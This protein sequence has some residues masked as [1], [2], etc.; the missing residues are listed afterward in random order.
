LVTNDRPGL[1]ATVSRVFLSFDIHLH[2]AKIATAGER[3]EDMF[4]ITNKKNRPLSTDE[5]EILSQKLKQELVL[6]R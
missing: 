2:N 1:L 6:A 4:Y 3:V 5:K